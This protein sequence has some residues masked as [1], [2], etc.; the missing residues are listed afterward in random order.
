MLKAIAR[1]P[2]L[3]NGRAAFYTNRTIAEGLMI[4][5]K[6]V[7][8]S[9]L[10]FEKAANQLGRNINQLTFQGIPVRLMDQMGVAETLVA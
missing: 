5:A 9:F 3:N 4:Q 8:Q 2:N 7:N 1:I 6:A 10:G